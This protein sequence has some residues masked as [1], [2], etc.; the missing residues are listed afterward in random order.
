VKYFS[1]LILLVIAVSG[2][3]QLKLVYSFGGDAIQNETEFYLDL[4][5]EEGAALERRI[6]ELVSWHRVKMLPLYAEFFRKGAEAVDR[7]AL[8]EPRV[9]LVIEE[10]QYLLRQ[11]VE[12]AVPHVATVMVGHT[13]PRKLNHL[14]ARMAE[15]SSERRK[16]LEVP[17]L[18]WLSERTESSV[19]RFR[20]FFGDLSEVQ[21]AMV[22]RYF[23]ETAGSSKP[24]QRVREDRRQAFLAFLSGR[25]DQDQI[26]KFLSRIMLHSEEIVGPEYKRLA[27]AWWARFT[28]WMVEM[29]GSL[30]ANQRQYFSKT[31]RDYADDM[32]DL[33]S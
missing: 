4:N 26:A 16:E 31:L 19:R 10:M 7:G 30:D 2:C 24:W 17:K 29:M 6:E 18:E 12:G 33:S 27:V 9:R 23:A 1:I 20:R 3:S 32:I 22:R 25:P 13:K 28:D 21:V 5:E 8:D 15:R 11:T 14:R